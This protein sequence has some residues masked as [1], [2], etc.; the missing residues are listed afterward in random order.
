MNLRRRTLTIVGITTLVLISIVLIT[1]LTLILT[2]VAQAERIQAEE[3]RTR[4]LAAFQLEFDSFS[5]QASQFAY[6]D[7]AYDFI[8]EYD[9]QFPEQQLRNET[10][11]SSKIYTIHYLDNE[12]DKIFLKAVN[13]STGNETVIPGEIDSMVKTNQNLVDFPLKGSYA[14]LLSLPNGMVIMASRAI[15]H[16]DGS[17]PRNGTLIMSRL[18]DTAFLQN[19]GDVS[20]VNFIMLP[21]NYPNLPEDFIEAK[22]NISATSPVHISTL[23]S[24]RTAAYS[25]LNDING[26]PVIYLRMDYL[27]VVTNQAR[28]T[29]IYLVASLLAVGIGIAIAVSILIGRF[30]VSPVS[31]LNNNVLDIGQSA[32]LSRRVTVLG[33]EEILSL[34][35]SVNALLANIEQ[36]Q[37]NLTRSF[38]QLSTISDIN[39]AI[40]GVLDPDLLLQQVVNL[41]QSRLN[42][43]YVGVFLVDKANEFAVLRAGT[44]EAGNAML[45]QGHKLA[46][47]GTSMIGWS[48]AKQKARIA[49]DVGKEAVRFSNP[50]LPRTRSELAIPIISR[51]LSIGAMTLQSDQVNAFDEADIIVFQG[52]ADSL[53]IALENANLFRQSQENLEEIRS[54]NRAYLIS[55]WAETFKT[56]GNLEYSY[57]NP[58][59]PRSDIEFIQRIPLKLRDQTLGSISLTISEEDLSAEQK[60]LIDTIANQTAQA[61]ENVRLLQESQKRAMQ[62]QQL[63]DLT[64]KFSSALNVNEIIRTAAKEFGR[65]PAVSEVTVQIGAAI[66]NGQD[67][68]APD[69]SENQEKIA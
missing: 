36:N 24:G 21:Y 48:T 15:L 2:N 49:L 9:P 50:L 58:E 39:R 1:M 63:N 25:L 65:L 57:D 53:A 14:G 62:E 60:N 19:L 37:L 55:A 69:I 67:T 38:N 28:Q 16:S 59:A 32:D 35:T 44:G 29:I 51:G 68:S 8:S 64:M 61:L 46:I 43:Y 26:Q 13:P 3:L 30:V 47:G 12:N 10:L 4:V 17:G 40:S 45:A 18:I 42:L 27:S 6:R 54:L 5:L 34:G 20:G 7:D 33:D 66:E 22:K 41:I 23:A 31:Q 56:K 11:I 52:I